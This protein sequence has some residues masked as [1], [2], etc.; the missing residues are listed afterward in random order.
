MSRQLRAADAAGPWD[1]DVLLRGAR[2]YV[3]PR[4][5]QKVEPTAEYQALMARLR[6]GAEAQA[7]AALV[8]RSSPSPEDKD[9]L[10]YASARRQLAL[11][12]NMLVSIVA[13]GVALWMAAGGWSAARRVGLCLGGSGV[14]GVAEVVVYAGYL[15]RVGEA[16]RRAR[17]GGE[18]K[19]VLRSW[20]VGGK[21]G[22][23][24]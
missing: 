3:P 16:R 6:R 21:E 15:R 4:A 17:R 8:R 19:V 12:L 10:T 14:V 23:E 22:K 11:V 24:E 5:A 9:E 18:R 7:Y 1:L 13:C 20:G 2:V